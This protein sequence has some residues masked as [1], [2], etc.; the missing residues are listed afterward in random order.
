MAELSFLYP[1]GP[2][3]I[4]DRVIALPEGGRI[5][6]LPEWQYI[7]T[8][9]HA[10]GHIS[11]FRESDKVLIAGDAFVTT[12]QESAIA[13]M[14]QTKKLSGPPK[15]FTPDWLSAAWSVEQLAKLEPD[16][17]ATGHGRPMRGAGMRKSLHNLARDFEKVAVPGQG[18]YVHQPALMDDTGVVSVPPR[19]KNAHAPMLKLLGI[20]AAILLTMLLFK[21]KKKKVERALS[22]VKENIP[23]KTA[24]LKA[25]A[26]SALKE[27]AQAAS[28]VQSDLKDKARSVVKD[29]AKAASDAIS[30]SGIKDKAQAALKAQSDMKDE[31]RSAIKDKAASAS[32]ALSQSA[33][34]VKAKTKTFSDESYLND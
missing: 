25:K 3:N 32:K 8:P 30:R 24:A 14:F 12:R 21:S 11:L 4:E 5:P 34:K 9:G 13:V 17:V 27:K 19:N 15:Y 23:E 6:G 20:S 28:R 18:R 7:H 29:K 10:P 2:I 31:A 22:K 1:K 33:S 26:Q 16:V